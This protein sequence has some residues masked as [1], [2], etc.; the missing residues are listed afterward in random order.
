MRDFLQLDQRL[1][2]IADGV[3]AATAL[4]QDRS[5]QVAF[6]PV[7]TRVYASIDRYLS[8][9]DESTVA[10]AGQA[11]YEQCS[12]DI[13]DSIT[14]LDSF[15]SSNSGAIESARAMRAAVPDRAGAAIR[16][17]DQAIAAAGAMPAEFS[18][19]TSVRSAVERVQRVR[20]AFDRARGAAAGTATGELNTQT[21]ELTT[22]ADELT[23]AV[24][25][26][27]GRVGEVERALSSVR[28]RWS[29]VRTRAERLPEAYSALL[30]EF[31]AACSED[32]TGHDRNGDRALR[33]AAG[34]IDAA[35]TL[36]GTDPD[37]A[38]GEVSAARTALADAEHFIDGV[39]DRLG[40]LRDVRA[41]P[42]AVEGRVRFGIRD[43]QLLAV[44]RG[45]VPRWG[46]VLDA[47]AARADR[48]SA[49]LNGTHPDYWGYVTEMNDIAAFVS[50]VVSKMKGQGRR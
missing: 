33:L 12:R 30:R 36:L 8:L 50:D 27:P 44:D 17:S 14:A 29:A 4:R 6:E 9:T 28:T 38:G 25:A 31:S 24:D 19:Y 26:A 40:T 39:T 18:G 7:R 37:H 46:S 3:D 35:A 11:E 23:A 43:A 2:I 42:G 45:L 22:A 32:L 13:H 48:A 41:D 49:G 47:A 10:R 20:S 21:A 34:H 15:Y 1:S 5:L 16:A